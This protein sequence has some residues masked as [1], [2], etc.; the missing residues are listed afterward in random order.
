MKWRR[1]LSE[2]LYYSRQERK[3]ILSLL[4][5]IL[6]VQCFNFF[7]DSLASGDHPDFSYFR[8][9]A[10]VYHLKLREDSLSYPEK[11]SKRD[12]LF[13]FNPNEVSRQALVDL[14][15]PERTAATLIRY[16]QKGGS[17]DEKEDLKKIYGFPDSLYQKLEPYIRLASAA[18]EKSVP[19][20]NRSLDPNTATKDQLLKLGLSSYAASNLIK[21][22]EK[23]GT[24]R[25]L[26]DIE[27]IYGFDADQ[28]EIARLYFVF[29]ARD[30]QPSPNEPLIIDINQSDS[31]TWQ[32]LRGIGPA[33][34]GRILKFRDKL[35]GFS[36]IQ[37]VGETWGVP[38]S[39]FQQIVPHL[40]LSPLYRKI[41]INT[42]TV[43][44]LK[45]HPYLS[46]KQAYW[47]H[48]YRSLH[49]PISSVEVLINSPLFNDA[50]VEKLIPYLEF[51]L[52]DD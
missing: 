19:S 18:V 35:G 17:F 42:A 10:S 29:P 15:V 20:V 24:Y 48:R 41:P 16:R 12:S 1:N 52:K 4:L 14:G 38:D 9:A 3:G 49:G 37:Q 7:Q 26:R 43:D 22:R 28:L 23:G 13:A 45:V 25:M 30:P 33:Y 44:E 11:V 8:Q 6:A 5:I 32:Q 40:K 50:A 2:Y 27:K 34:A 31:Q 47:I 51:G 21:Y 36:S 39:V 46:Y